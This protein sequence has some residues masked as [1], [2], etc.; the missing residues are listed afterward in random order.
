MQ[1]IVRSFVFGLPYAVLLVFLF[2][3][4]AC[5]G[6]G[7]GNNN[8]FNSVSQNSVSSLGSSSSSVLSVSS[9]A[10]STTSSSSISSSSSQIF[11][12]L[13]GNITYDFVP[14]NSNHVG[15]NYSAI[16]QRPVRGA[17]IEA[18]DDTGK[19]LAASSTREDGG[20]SF[21]LPQNTV[22]KIRVKAQLLKTGAT[23]W[24]FKVTD[25]T[26]NNALY[27]LDGNLG[28]LD[29]QNSK[30]N[31]NAGSGWDGTTYSAVRAAAPFAMLDNIYDAANRLLAAGNTKALRPLELRWSTKNSAADGDLTLG[32]I[33]T[34]FY[35]GS[36][37]YILG[38]A[39]HDTD[40]YD[41]HVLLHEWGHYI[42]RQLYRSDSIGGS[43]S[44]GDS[45]DIR[46]AMSEGFANSFSGMML[47]DVN[48]ADAFGE[49]QK[50]GFFFNIGRKSLLNKGAFNERSIGSVLFN[51]YISADN[52]IAND[53]TPIHT[54]LSSDA[55]IK[56][57]SFASIYL[58]AQRLGELF[59]AQKNSFMG[60]LNGQEI[61]GTDEY[62]RNES[63]SGG[64]VYVLPIYKELAP[65]NKSV[66]VCSSTEFG[67]N[68]KLGNAQYL[69]LSISQAGVYNIRLNKSGG[70]DVATKPEF[71]LYFKGIPQ[72]YLANTQPDLI[73]GNLN[74]AQGNYLLE[75]YDA[76]NR[77]AKNTDSNTTCFDVRATA[78]L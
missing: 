38:D 10:S 57:E 22:V 65:N 54:I 31:L 23:A 73:A 69:K 76:N 29:S 75:V 26:S 3:L 47:N 6:G 70:V 19:T 55:Y 12:N 45:L 59:S 67:K 20:Y 78:N 15:L 27:V 42:E 35:D 30:R 56:A 7:G 32:E 4:S 16:E 49:A 37:I 18:L 77:D 5:G 34:S 53:Y 24:D 28:S 46:V 40:E 71:I 74:L 8:Q 68:N 60:L 43:H 33:G 58:F 11:V 41:A 61:F 13:S 9:I 1:P 63:N 62:A 39:D 36:A 52:K 48:Y 51:Y 66:N 25:N 44:D 2:A 64:S 17:A 14:H 21:T 50:Q 72:F